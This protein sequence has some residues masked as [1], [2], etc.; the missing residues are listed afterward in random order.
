[1]IPLDKSNAIILPNYTILLNFMILHQPIIF[2]LYAK[3]CIYDAQLNSSHNC[4]LFPL[5]LCF[6]LKDFTNILS[7]YPWSVAQQFYFFIFL[8]ISYLEDLGSI[9]IDY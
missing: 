3:I 7:F 9:I 6:T 4:K 5:I 1:M 2:C 8:L